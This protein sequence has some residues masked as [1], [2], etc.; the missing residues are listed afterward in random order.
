[1]SMIANIILRDPYSK[2]TLK[3]PKTL[4]LRPLH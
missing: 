1:M 2:Y 3:E 4:L